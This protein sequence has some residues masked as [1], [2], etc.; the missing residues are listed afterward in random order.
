MAEIALPFEVKRLICDYVDLPTIKSLRLVSQSW[1]AV[2]SELL[3]LS[4]FTIKSSAT[5]ISRLLDIGS[6]PQVAQQAAKTIRTLSFW[7]SD[8]DIICLRSILCSRH[9]HLSNYEVVDFVPNQQESEALEEL[10]ALIEQRKL[11]VIRDESIALLAQALKHVPRL[12][13]LHISCPNPFKH[14]LLRKVWEEYDLETYRNPS[15][16][17]GPLRL[18]KILVAARDAGLDIRHLQHEQ[19]NSNYFF[20]ET[21][22]YVPW[23]FYQHLPA[24]RSLSLVIN[25]LQSDLSTLTVSLHGDTDTESPSLPSRNTISLPPTLQS[26]SIKFESLNRLSIS[27]LPPP[28]PALSLNSLSLIGTSISPTLFLNFLN[29]HIPSL[30][31]LC[32]GSVELQTDQQD[33]D[34]QVFL[35]NLRDSLGNRLQK[36]QLAGVIKSPNPNGP[37]WMF[38]PIYRTDGDGGDWEELPPPVQPARNPNARERTREMEGFAIGG[39]EWPM[40]DED[41]ISNFVT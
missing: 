6:R 35:S 15:F 32:L 1:A 10:D 8:W 34:W 19:F 21:N 30:R 14:P 24:L 13:K 26:L 22:N 11:N 3:F 31:H 33:Y 27:F 36:F 40:K 38:W 28:T 23:D 17:F 18:L 16:R 25:D 20:D 4:T 12:Q 5:D 7:S 37:I 2:G 9:V 39:G 29:S 41:D